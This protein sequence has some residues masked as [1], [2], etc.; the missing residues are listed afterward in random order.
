MN[1]LSHTFPT[2][3]F[4][5]FAENTDGPNKIFF[6]LGTHTL[7]PSWGF[8][9]HGGPNSVIWIGLPLQVVHKAIRAGY[10][11]QQVANAIGML[12]RHRASSASNMT[13]FAVA[14]RD[15]GLF[16]QGGKMDDITVLVSFVVAQKDLA[17]IKKAGAPAPAPPPIQP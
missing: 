3:F 4:G 2:L 11:P 8:L 6:G 12:A 15:S 13:P 14:A 17:K 7:P 1:R 16:F 10:G 5:K 9:S